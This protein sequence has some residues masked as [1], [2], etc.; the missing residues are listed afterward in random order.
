MKER[1]VMRYDENN[2]G[3]G[4]DFGPLKK[5][6]GCLVDIGIFAGGAYLLKACVQWLITP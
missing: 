5:A 2:I 3:I 1:N 4:I 6:L